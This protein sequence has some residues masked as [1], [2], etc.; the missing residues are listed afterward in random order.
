MGGRTS[1]CSVRL[2]RSTRF[3]RRHSRDNHLNTYGEHV[4]QVELQ[5]DE[6]R[7]ARRTDY[8]GCHHVEG[9]DRH[10]LQSGRLVLHILVRHTEGESL[11]EGEGRA[12]GADELC[13]RKRG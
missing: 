1:A 4:Q 12:K 11:L 3:A 6:L 8:E 7:K 10:D 9:H 2:L 13:G 5:C